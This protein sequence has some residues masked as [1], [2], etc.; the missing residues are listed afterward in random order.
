MIRAM[1]VSCLPRIQSKA[2]IS[3]NSSEIIWDASRIFFIFCILS[4]YHFYNFLKLASQTS[5]GP[6]MFL[7]SSEMR[8]EFFNFLWF[9]EIS[10]LDV[11]G[12]SDVFEIIWEASRLFA[13]IFLIFRRLRRL[14]AL[15]SFRD[16]LRC[17]SNFFIFYDFFKLASQTSEGPQK[18]SR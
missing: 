10:V 4:L 16:N 6:Q 8:L 14:R 9:L 2:R 5:E 11:W 18:F 12:P 13:F 17:V 1:S 3:H 15:R 7:R